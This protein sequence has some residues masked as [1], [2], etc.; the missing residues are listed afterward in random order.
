MQAL[1]EP[2]ASP[3]ARAAR[4]AKKVNTKAQT[5]AT[6]PEQ[7][8]VRAVR[9]EDLP[10]VVALD[11]RVTGRR[12]AEAWQQVFRRYGVGGKG[13]RHFLVAVAGGAVLGF[14]VGEVR[15]WEFGSPR[16]GWVLSVEV[17]PEARQAGL[18]SALLQAITARFRR[19]GAHVV[20]TMLA[21]DNTLIL[22]FFRS[23]GMMASRLLLLEMDIDAGATADGATP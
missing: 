15:D 8:Q 4:A 7:F 9:P 11:A 20:R 21:R 10:Q 6:A 18:G 16:C 19:A 23:Q 3:H 14:V 12:Q 1:T 13:T 22:S 5:K 17:D 2:L